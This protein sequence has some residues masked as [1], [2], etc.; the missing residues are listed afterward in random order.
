MGKEL[1][2]ILSKL[3]SGILILCKIMGCGGHENVLSSGTIIDW[4]IQ[5]LIC[6]GTHS[7]IHV[8]AM[9]PK[10][11]FQAMSPYGA[12]CNPGSFL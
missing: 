3:I 2:N 10:W 11:S 4:W 6:F 12:D 1:G 5:V 7:H 8:K 9:I